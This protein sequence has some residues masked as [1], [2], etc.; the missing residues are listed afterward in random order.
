MFRKVVK[1]LRMLVCG[2][3]GTVGWVLATLDEVG[4]LVFF[5]YLE[6]EFGQSMTPLY[7]ACSLIIVQLLKRCHFEVITQCRLVKQCILPAY[8]PES[9]GLP[10]ASL[11]KKSL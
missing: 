4:A 11:V 10:I 8:F 2:G 9:D 1:Q 3:D 7:I 5:L 6:R